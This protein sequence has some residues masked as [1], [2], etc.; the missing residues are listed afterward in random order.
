[1]MTDETTTDETTT[2]PRLAIVAEALTAAGATS[3]PDDTDTVALKIVNALDGKGPM[4]EV[5]ADADAEG[6]GPAPVGDPSASGTHAE[7]NPAS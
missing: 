5:T 7:T 6:N 4:P 3:G 1:M 2:D